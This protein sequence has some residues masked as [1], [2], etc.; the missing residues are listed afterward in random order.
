MNADN[1]VEGSERLENGFEN[2]K[3]LLMVHSSRLF[4]I[5]LHKTSFIHCAGVH[6]CVCV[7]AGVRGVVYNI[8]HYAHARKQAG[9]VDV[10]VP[11]MLLFTSFARQ[12]RKLNLNETVYGRP[13]LSFKVFMFRFVIQYRSTTRDW[14][15]WTLQLSS[16][17]INIVFML[18]F[19]SLITLKWSFFTLQ[20]SLK[21][22]FTFRDIVKDC[23]SSCCLKFIAGNDKSLSG[24]KFEIAMI[25]SV[26]EDRKISCCSYV[27]K[28]SETK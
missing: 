19:L 8:F 13:L 5:A 6:V 25:A 12:D 1:Y 21:L 4:N 9:N 24:L 22:L 26:E 10:V 2:L 3:P 28:M 15:K 14:R 23:D 7:F 18:F 16:C 11:G 27:V 17:K 20:Y